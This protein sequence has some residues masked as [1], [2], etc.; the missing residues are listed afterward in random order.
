MG[1]FEPAENLLMKVK[2]ISFV[3][4]GK[5]PANKK[6]VFLLKTE[7]DETEARYRAHSGEENMELDEKNIEL[8]RISPY[9]V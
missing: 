9:T 3:G 5:K 7:G 2:E 1:Q 4:K 6:A 8:E